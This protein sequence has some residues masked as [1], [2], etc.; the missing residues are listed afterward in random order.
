[1]YHPEATQFQHP[2]HTGNFFLRPPFESQ[3]RS[4]FASPVSILSRLAPIVNRPPTPPPDMNSLAPT[5][6][7]PRY[8]ENPY[9]SYRERASVAP[10][11]PPVSYEQTQD[12]RDGFSRQSNMQVRSNK[13]RSPAP[14]QSTV[15]SVAGPA[16]AQSRKSSH[17]YSIAPYLQIP[18][19]INSSQGSLS[20]LAA[21]ITCLFW[22]E[23]SQELELA[24]DPSSAALLP[25]SLVSDAIPTT[26]FRKWVTTILSTTQVAQNVILLALLFIY[27]LKKLNPSVKGKPGSEYRLL[28]VAL[29]LG[30][31]FLDDNTYTNKTW[32][33][34]SGISVGEVHIMEVEFLSNMKYALFTSAEEW[35]E[36]QTL[37]GRFAGFVDRATRPQPVASIPQTA[38]PAAYMPAALPSPP[39]SYQASPPFTNGIPPVYPSYPQSIMTPAHGPT[40]KPSPLGHVPD[41]PPHNP[42]KRSLDDVS[43]EPAS[44]RVLQSPAYSH[45]YAGSNASSESATSQPQHVTQI[46]HANLPMPQLA[47]LYPSSHGAHS[48][49]YQAP[50][51]PPLNYLPKVAANSYTP[52]TW[53]Q[54]SAMTVP[55]SFAAQ[56][57][58]NLQSNHSSRQQ[59]PYLRSANISPK[60][61]A[62]RAASQA[63]GQAQSSPSIFLHQRNSPYKPVRGVSTLLVPPPARAMHQPEN[64][65]HDQIHYQ[66]LGRPQER[67]QGRLPYI[68]QNQWLD[69]QPKV[70]TPVDQWPQFMHA[71]QQPMLPVPAARYA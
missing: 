71:H 41:F 37:L 50:Q 66:P 45:R 28:T 4:A 22:F 61:G 11:Q 34:V 35:S 39:A 1:M 3:Y 19:S 70:T 56:R 12:L 48:Q 7:T 67:Q 65:D 25:H 16:P 46:N 6:H 29:M 2:L 9:T 60:N 40:P 52:N 26:G 18:R 13:A 21:Q 33:E 51:L 55:P 63:H 17:N 43:G 53:T 36:W 59:S 10:R 47:Q 24:E 31:K 68:A 62:L 15:A 44:K 58:V 30:N 32:A 5:L 64:V 20:E 8:Q 23:S 54:T 14:R 42:R 27:R 57:S 69:H 38:V 49:Q